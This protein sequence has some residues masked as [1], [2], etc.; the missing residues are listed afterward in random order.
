MFFFPEWFHATAV[1][2]EPEEPDGVRTIGSG[3]IIFHIK[4]TIKSYCNYTR[5]ITIPFIIGSRVVTFSEGL[6]GTYTL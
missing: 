4:I 5:E 1:F 6:G 3:L 2:V